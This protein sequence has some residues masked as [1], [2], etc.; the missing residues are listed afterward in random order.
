MGMALGEPPALLGALAERIEQSGLSE[1]K[2]W[3]FHSMPEAARTVL[4]YEFM[5]RLNVQNDFK[6]VLSLLDLLCLL[7]LY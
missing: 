4:K 1:L 2:L 5:D 7:I 6:T 3:Y